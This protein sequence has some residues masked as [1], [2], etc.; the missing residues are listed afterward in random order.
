VRYTERHAGKAVIRNKNLLPL[1]IEK[2]AAL[3]EA[4]CIPGMICDQ[5]CKHTNK[6]GVL[7][8]MESHCKSCPLNELHHIM[9]EL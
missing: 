1:A 6:C 8:D 5:I 7:E 9:Q 2:L 4:E 3:E